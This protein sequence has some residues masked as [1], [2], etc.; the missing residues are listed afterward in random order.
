MGN[1]GMLRIT[2]STKVNALLASFISSRRI[3]KLKEQL[4]LG[5]TLILLAQKQA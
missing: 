3:E 1:R 5:Y 4:G 2:N